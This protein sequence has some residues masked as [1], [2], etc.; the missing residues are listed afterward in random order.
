VC[1]RKKPSKIILLNLLLNQTN[2]TVEI[3]HETNQQDNSE[4]FLKPPWKFSHSFMIGI[5]VLVIGL[6]IETVTNGMT[7]Q[8]IGAPFN[9]YI[10][11]IFCSLILF[12]HF[13][14]RKHSIVQ[15]MSSIPAAVSAISLYAILV[16][17]LGFIRQDDVQVSE[18]IRLLGLNHVK[19]GWPFLLIQIYV[20]TILGVVTLRRTLP[21]S[22]KNLGFFLNHFGLW[23]VL[24]SAGLGAGDLQRLTINLLENENDNNIG[25]SSHGEVCKLPF[26]LKL[27]D[28]T[29]DEYPAK[30]AIVNS[31]TGNLVIADKA[32]ALPMAEKGLKTKLGDWQ[33]EVF[34]YLPQAM[35]KDSTVEK[36]EI[37]G[38]CPAALIKAQNPITRQKVQGW[39]MSGSYAQAPVILRLQGSSMMVLSAA[40]PR[41]YSST[42]QIKIDST[43]V[44]TVKLAVNKPF[45]VRGWDLYQLSYDQSKGKWS[46]LSVLEAVRDPWMPLVYTGLFMLMG[47]AIILFWTGRKAANQ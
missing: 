25:I 6:V 42:L 29:I 40:E 26:T 23:L 15:W 32:N 45:S 5:S 9:I 22:I 43:H 27:L 4:V 31:Q 1:G 37:A 3:Q 36:S 18:N 19:T 2:T 8:P 28:F 12:L 41:K 39:L 20:L 44:D 16:L 34:D 38:S 30:L 10:G 33:I 17:V 21:F 35:M 14:Y 13:G 46:T 7:I 47:G 24:L 11:F